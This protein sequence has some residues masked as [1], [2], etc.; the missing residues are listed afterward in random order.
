MEGYSVV[1]VDYCKDEEAYGL[2]DVVELQL[3]SSYDY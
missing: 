1:S 2:P 3:L